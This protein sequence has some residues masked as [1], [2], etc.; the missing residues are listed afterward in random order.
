RP[1]NL[2]CALSP[3]LPPL[4]RPHEN[5][6]TVYQRNLHSVNCMQF[7]VVSD[8]LLLRPLTDPIYCCDQILDHCSCVHCARV[9]VPLPQ[10]GFLPRNPE[11]QLS[12]TSRQLSAFFPPQRIF[13]RLDRS[14]RQPES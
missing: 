6:I 5:L 4:C 12:A 14:S 8:A 10:F 3:L 11:E 1:R 7:L 13:V 2:H 9:H